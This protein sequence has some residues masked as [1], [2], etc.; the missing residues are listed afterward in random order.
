MIKKK[1]EK[2]K[3]RKKK[4]RK[5]AFP[6]NSS[7]QRSLRAAR[8]EGAEGLPANSLRPSGRAA[9]ARPRGHGG[10]CRA[11]LWC[12][13]RRPLR[14]PPPAKEVFRASG[15]SP[16]LLTWRR[17]T[18]H[19]FISSAGSPGGKFNNRSRR[20]NIGYKSSPPFF[21]PSRFPTS[22]SY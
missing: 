12:A 1:R 7:R 10:L 8:H 19:L 6:S 16:V 13:H 9:P 17:G 2:K 14:P 20:S 15:K 5:K 18:A 21:F 4:K 3:E 11:A 22:T